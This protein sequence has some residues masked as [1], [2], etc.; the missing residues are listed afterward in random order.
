VI[1]E[2][3]VVEGATNAGGHADSVRSAICFVENKLNMAAHNVTRNIAG[4][5]DNQLD[6]VLEKG[7]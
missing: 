7:V 1:G 4:F 2:D 3:E 6:S 5:V